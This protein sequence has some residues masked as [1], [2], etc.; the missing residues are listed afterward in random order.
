[1][2]LLL[3]FSVI[4]SINLSILVY[5]Y[6]LLKKEF[7]I[8]TLAIELKNVVKQY[9]GVTALDGVDLKVKKGSIHGFLGPNGAGKSTTMNIIAGLIPPTSGDV[10]VGG[11]S[12]L[13]DTKALRTMIGL[14]PESPPL[15][16]NMRVKDFLIF[17][18]K[19]N[20]LDPSKYES[21]D[22][23]MDKCG[24]TD[25]SNRLIG[26]LSKGY[27]QRVG[28]AQALVYGAETIILDEPTVGLDPNAIA[29]V[30]NLILELKKEHTI[31]LS[32]HQ[33]HEVARICDEITIINKG[34]ILKTGTLV[35]VQSEFSSVK[36][37][38]FIHRNFSD[39][40]KNY[41]VKKDYVSGIDTLNIQEDQ[42]TIRVH[43]N[44]NHDH[45]SELLSFLSQEGD[46]LEFWERKLELEEIFKQVVK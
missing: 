34:K 32:T 46:L 22:P 17:C 1:M 25:V 37:Y 29:E 28:M 10:F 2:N 23:I 16:M 7:Q 12:A 43:I 8:M 31:L 44:S 20:L 18:Q 30:R 39:D 3:R 41:L 40:I 13:E 4:D 45:R 11:V 42:K 21:I 26:N 9:P 33:L 14:L 15:Y 6:F 5:S 36:T 19:I 35:E 24:L 27:K 38:E